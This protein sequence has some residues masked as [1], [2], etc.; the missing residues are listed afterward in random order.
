MHSEA[1]DAWARAAGRADGIWHDKHIAHH[2]DGIANH[3]KQLAELAIEHEEAAQ[4]LRAAPLAKRKSEKAKRDAVVHGLCEVH[5]TFLMGIEDVNTTKAIW[6]WAHD[7]QY[8]E[9]IVAKHRLQWTR[10][11][12]IVPRIQAR[13]LR[14]PDVRASIMQ[15]QRSPEDLAVQACGFRMLHMLT[16]S[17]DAVA[18]RALEYGAVKVACDGLSFALTCGH[19]EQALEKKKQGTEVV[20]AATH[21]QPL[22]LPLEEGAD[23]QYPEEE[24]NGEVESAVLQAARPAV[25]VL[26][27][28]GR[29]DEVARYQLSALGAFD[30][31][32]HAAKRFPDDRPLQRNLCDLLVRLCNDDI[33]RTLA[34]QG[35]TTVQLILRNFS[36]EMG[37]PMQEIA[38]EAKSIVRL[39]AKQ[40]EA[41][42]AGVKVDTSAW[43]NT[44][45]WSGKEH[46][47]K[48]RALHVRAA[49]TRLIIAALDACM[50]LCAKH[51]DNK[52][53]ACSRG[54][55]PVIMGLLSHYGNPTI[56]NESRWEGS[57]IVSRSLH[58]I[59]TLCYDPHPEFGDEVVYKIASELMA[60]EAITMMCTAAH[61]HLEDAPIQMAL[62]QAVYAMLTALGGVKRSK[63]VSEIGNPVRDGKTDVSNIPSP[64]LLQCLVSSTKAHPQITSIL[65]QA[66]V[67][68][69]A[70]CQLHSL[71]PDWWMRADGPQVFAD[72]FVAHL[73]VE[74]V[75][76]QLLECFWTLCQ[77]PTG[78]RRAARLRAMT[79]KQIQR[80]LFVHREA[81]TV[82]HWAT[83]ARDAMARTGD[84][85][86]DDSSSVGS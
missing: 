15:L 3:E 66:C 13:H 44:K 54:V 9:D 39:A 53:D 40:R 12:N 21:V 19:G 72:A 50:A 2:V 67:N 24:A 73:Y 75:Q 28:L 43:E 65:W 7:H 68:V 41:R 58:C 49:D 60:A 64:L 56:L 48:L 5:E 78:K 86:D 42:A 76:E 25:A 81:P 79:A 32:V 69:T 57:Q 14:D 16:A 26:A 29:V 10:R 20:V 31:A 8:Q 27:N 38:K 45:E 55:L 17:S 63:T 51:D 74:P 59:W 85:H 4:K 83:Q 35:G 23:Q 46:F 84:E 33:A 6:H 70:M 52:R 36:E 47:A 11:R 18:L 61:T 22:A 82:L 37:W 71:V 77:G 62:Q 1:N 30:T 34:S 80:C